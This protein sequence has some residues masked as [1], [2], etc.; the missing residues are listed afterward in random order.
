MSPEITAN[1]GMRT[2]EG[3]TL[4]SG[5][6]HPIA[7]QDT[8]QDSQKNDRNQSKKTKI[9]RSKTIKDKL[10]RK[11]QM[12]MANQKL[13]KSLLTKVRIS[14]TIGGTINHLETSI[15]H[16]NEGHDHGLTHRGVLGKNLIGKRKKKVTLLGAHLGKMRSLAARFLNGSEI[17]TTIVALIGVVTEA[18]DT[19]DGAR[20]EV[21][22][23]CLMKGMKGRIKDQRFMIVI[24][25]EN[26]TTEGLNAD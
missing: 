26:L 19:A 18:V 7:N 6:L 11:R 12:N 17:G 24:R 8:R 23:I 14:R 15:D 5:N 22:I 20:T 21:P 16:T 10:R 25:T 3:L 2:T 9:A 4:T 1:R 13:E